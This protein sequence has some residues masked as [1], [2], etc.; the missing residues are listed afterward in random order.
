[1]NK[2]LTTAQLEKQ[3][4][5]IDEA[6]KI[7]KKGTEL[8]RTINTKDFLSAF[9][10]LTAIT[11]QAEIMQHH[12]DIQLSYG[13]LKVSITSHEQGGLTKK[14]IQLASVVDTICR[15]V[16]DNRAE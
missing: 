8:T 14:D 9:T 12:P 15:E 7:A 2:L 5:S 1:M 16:G 6:W 3:K 11:V 10:L 4:R 13:K